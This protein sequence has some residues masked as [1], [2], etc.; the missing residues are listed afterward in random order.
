MSSPCRKAL[1]LLPIVVVVSAL[2]VL[3]GGA[4]LSS[5]AHGGNA[6]AAATGASPNVLPGTTGSIAPPANSP[7]SIFSGIS[8]TF[9]NAPW[10]KSLTHTGPALKALASLPNINILKGGYTSVSAAI[11]PFYTSPPAPLGLGDFGLGAKTYSYNT[12]H[13]LG[14]VTFNTPPNATNPGATDLILPPLIAQHQGYIGSP[15]TFGIQLNTIA[16]NIT[17]PGNNADFLW[18]QNVVNWNDT[19]IHFVSDTFNA[20]YNGAIDPGTIYSACGL[21]ASGAQTVLDVYGGVFQCVGGTIPVSP[22]SYPVTLQLYNNAS[23][24]AANQSEVSYGYRLIEAGTGTV[25]TGVSDVIVF[26]NPNPA[27][28]SGYVAPPPGFTV[29]GFALT[30]GHFLR[31]SEIVIVGGI[32]G[33]NAVFRSINGSINLEYSNLTSG[34]WKN[35]PSAYNFG[36]DTGETS[37]GIADYWTASHTLEINSGP[38][39]LYGLWNAAPW[40]SVASGDIQVAGTITPSYGFVFLGNTAPDVYG[41]NLSWVPTT[42]SG[43]FDTYLPPLGAP[44]TTTYYVQAFAAGS[45][46]TN[47]TVTASTTSL[48]IVLPLASGV[49]RAPLYAYSNAQMAELAKNVTGSSTAPYVFNGLTLNLNFTFNHLNDYTYPVFTMFDSQGVTQPVYVNN[50]YQGYDSAF[51]NLYFYV[52][53][54]VQNG[55]LNPPGEILPVDLVG[56]TSQIVI[57]GGSGD[58][59][60]NETMIGQGYGAPYAQEGGAVI[61]WQDTNAQLNNIVSE[62]GSVGAWVGDSSGTSVTHVIAAFGY[63]VY[64]A[65]GVQDIGSAHTTVT[66]L[67]AAY[68]ATGIAAYAS[69]DATYSWINVTF[70]GM[71]I[72]AGF[73]EGYF[74]VNDAYYNLPGTVGATV[75]DLNV[76]LDANLGANFTNSVGTTLNQPS[77]FDPSFLHAAIL[78]L[79]AT[80]GTTINGMVANYAASFYAWNATNTAFNNAVIENDGSFRYGGVYLY[81][82]GTTFQG[83]TIT[84]DYVGVVGVYSTSTT[85]SNVMVTTTYGGFVLAF[86]T[87][88]VGSNLN[89]SYPATYTG[90]RFPYE[91]EDCTGPITVTGV[92]ADNSYIGLNLYHSDPFAVSNVVVN[93]SGESFY[94][95]GVGIYGVT[96]GTVTGVTATNASVGVRVSDGSTGVVVSTVSASEGSIGVYVD[97]SS[98]RISGVTA[99]YG[100]VGVQLLDSA[101][102][103]IS[104]TSASYF[105]VGDAIEHSTQVTD[106]GASATGG[107]ST[108]VYVLDSSFVSVS[109]TTATASVLGSLYSGINALDL[110]HAAVVTDGTTTTTVSNVNATNYGAALVDIGS[111]GLQ[112]SNVNGTGG[113]YAVALNGTYNSYFNGIGAYHDW[114]G[115]VMWGS[116]SYDN[117]VTGS[118]FVDDTSYGVAILLGEDN[119]LVMNNFI[120]DN[121]ATSTYS[122]AHVQA[123]S[124]SYNYFY[125]CTGV[126]A[127]GVGNY[128]AD[129]HTYGPNGFLA[130]YVI[131]GETVDEFP[132]GPQETFTVTFNAAGLPSG[133]SWSVTLGGMTQSSTTS[134]ISFAETMGSFS[135]QVNGPAGWT[136]TPS[137]GSVTV[138]GATYNVSVAFS[139]VVY[140]VTLSAGGISPGTS[141]SATVNGATQSTTGAS[142]VFYLGAGT[143]TYSFNAVNG[144][145]LPSAG[146]SG[147]VNVTGPTN[148]AVTYAPTSTP[149][150][151]TTSTYNT[152]F[153]IALVIAVI[154]LILALLALFWRRRARASENQAPPSAWS[155]PSGSATTAPSGGGTGTNQWSEG[156]GSPPS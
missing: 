70:G 48:N 32:G 15:Y 21:N 137:S 23:V 118:S 3:P 53:P 105:S 65:V 102:V 45:A 156:S 147:T 41:T 25:Y 145:N 103:T 29:D 115:L 50:T 31:D 127:T 28:P 59:V 126:C 64:Y 1:W 72:S 117:W 40:A 83:L 36:G 113:L 17:V 141:W 89:S 75:N 154:A 134:T 82:T 11:A 30:P 39:L 67:L 43:A 26:N 108:G 131:T 66:G 116:Y 58:R 143:Y 63:S 38:S 33:D 122:A 106:T 5:S 86:S 51:G 95:A 80:V 135:Y 4:F 27:P 42:D 139:Q 19:G 62:F 56:M 138:S 52:A 124:D 119:T 99:I 148:L 61:L 44:W 47:A 20:S 49:L 10:V 37:V 120:G 22:A 93:N 109:G 85:V 46:E 7:G 9:A 142:L 74:G 54:A 152:G 110:P 55:I 132:L 94:A 150:L 121:G 146:A 18:T 149:S 123:W 6:F 107:N 88:F 153:A 125:T 12:S 129:W 34:G 130:P 151:V 136:A 155:P 79:D 112:V 91:L 76:S 71:G 13:V 81:S 90:Y 98:A 78:N 104:G 144:Y 77:G 87:G 101:N 73:D 133:T 114:I 57:Y 128:W 97:P 140:A 111:N 16:T 96:G 24:N 8:P 2:M 14:Q 92:N 68:G 84:A 69:S 35:V 100:S 60:S